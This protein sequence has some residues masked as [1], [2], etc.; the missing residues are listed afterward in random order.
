MLLQQVA[1]VEDCRLA[2]DAVVTQFEACEVSHDVASV[3]VAL[4]ARSLLPF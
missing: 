3:V 1:E 4:N 2:G